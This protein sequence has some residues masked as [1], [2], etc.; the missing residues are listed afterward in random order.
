MVIQS[1]L[2]IQSPMANEIVLGPVKYAPGA[3]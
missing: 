1:P 3:S 2:V